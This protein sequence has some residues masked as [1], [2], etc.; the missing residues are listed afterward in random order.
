MKIECIDF[1]S[2]RTGTIDLDAISGD[3]GY[4]YT[5]QV[6]FELACEFAVIHVPDSHK[7][8]LNEDFGLVGVG[9]ISQI[10]AELDHDDE[11]G[12]GWISHPMSQTGFRVIE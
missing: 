10:W 4:R 11:F 8:K 7:L 9:I 6:A 12:G 5:Q 3:S 1:Q 2:G